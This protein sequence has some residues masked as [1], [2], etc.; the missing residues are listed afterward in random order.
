MIVV[1]CTKVYRDKNNVILG[2]DITDKKGK[3]KHIGK[4][5]LKSLIKTGEIIVENLTLTKDGRLIVQNSST[6]NSAG[7]SLRA[8]VWES[9]YQGYTFKGLTYFIEDNKVTVKATGSLKTA[10]ILQGTEVIASSAFE[11]CRGLGHVIIPEGVISIGK[12][13]FYKCGKLTYVA[14]PKTIKQIGAFAFSY[15]N[16]FRLTIPDGVKTIEENTF[17]SCKN[18]K[19]VELPS[20]IETIECRA[21][22]GCDMLTSIKIPEGVKTI[23]SYAFEKSGLTDITVPGECN[24]ARGLCVY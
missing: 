10:E 24:S 11:G 14:L 4:S 16:I 7:K 12:K 9:G 2:Y 1:K 5:E 20:T 18:L 6:S 21:F 15:T 19:N 8:K 22:S 3:T 23:D 13:A 17:E